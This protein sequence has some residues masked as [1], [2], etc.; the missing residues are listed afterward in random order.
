MH[1][2]WKTEQGVQVLEGWT[3]QVIM[4]LTLTR[5]SANWP[6]FLR[7]FRPSGSNLLHAFPKV[8]EIIT[9]RTFTL[10]TSKCGVCGHCL[11]HL[12]CV[13]Q[14]YRHGPPYRGLAPFHRR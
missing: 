11:F 12:Q 6:F 5:P 1:D 3:F 8:V 2:E 7:S 14:K 13:D 4:H 9:D 10:R